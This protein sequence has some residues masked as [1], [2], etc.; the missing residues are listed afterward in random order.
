MS[1]IADQL[2]NAWATTIMHTPKR[3]LCTWHVLRA[4]KNHLK[5]IK[6]L[7]TEEKLYQILKVL[8]DETDEHKFKQMVE[9]A[10]MEMKEKV[11]TKEFG[12]YFETNY[13]C[14]CEQWANCLECRLE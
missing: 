11:S 1:D 13:K 2:Y 3:I 4:W 5:T 10:V 12:E 9:M 14:R 6:D 8:M 7:D